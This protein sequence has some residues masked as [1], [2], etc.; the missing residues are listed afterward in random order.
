[1]AADKF[2]FVL[3]FDMCTTCIVF[4]HSFFPLEL[5]CFKQ[6][7]ILRHKRTGKVYVL[8]AVV[9]DTL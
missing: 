4:A 3:S 9:S 5:Y 7:Q 8:R 6:I 2:Y 1:M